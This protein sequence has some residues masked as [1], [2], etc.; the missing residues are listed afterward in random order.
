MNA[1]TLIAQLALQPHIEGGHFRRIYTSS[2]QTTNGP[3]GQRPLLSSI[4]YLL[5][6]AEPIG[7]LHRNRSD[8]VHFWQGGCALRYTLV[9]PAGALTT[10]LLGPDISNG[11]QL[12]LVVA[13]GCWKASQLL[14]PPGA[15]CD[16]GLVAEAVCP[17][18]DY[19]DQ[20]LAQAQQIRSKYPQH[21]PTLA[22]LIKPHHPDN[23]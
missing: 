3:R 16:Y 7:Y 1:R 23:P 19:Q 11:Q 21:W 2:R 12:S 22:P 5:S 13:G 14:L 6:T 10:A 17:G 9:S 8:I 20:Q 18:F 4:H 15:A